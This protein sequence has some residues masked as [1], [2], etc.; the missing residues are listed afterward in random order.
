MYIL[1]YLTEQSL[2]MSTE[3]NKKLAKVDIEL[4]ASPYVSAYM[5]ISSVDTFVAV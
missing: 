2:M 3:I 4:A 1:L 5:I